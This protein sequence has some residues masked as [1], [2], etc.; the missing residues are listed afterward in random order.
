MT[1]KYKFKPTNTTLPE[2]NIKKEGNFTQLPYNYKPYSYEEEKERFERE[3]EHYSIPEDY[4]D[5]ERD[6]E[7]HSYEEEK[8][9]F[10]R[11]HQHYSIS[12]DYRD[13]ERDPEPYSYE[14]EQHLIDYS[15]VPEYYCGSEWDPESDFYENEEDFIDP[16]V[17]DLESGGVDLST[18]N[19]QLPLSQHS[20]TIVLDPKLPKRYRFCS[21]AGL[22]TYYS[23][24][25]ELSQV[26]LWFL[27]KFQKYCAVRA[28]ISKQKLV[29]KL[30]PRYGG[31]TKPN[32]VLRIYFKLKRTL[33]TR[34]VN[35]FDIPSV[36]SKSSYHPVVMTDFSNERSFDAFRRKG[37]NQND[38]IQRLLSYHVGCLNDETMLFVDSNTRK[39]R[40]MHVNQFTTQ[41]IALRKKRALKVLRKKE[42][43]Y[44]LLK[45]CPPF[46]FKSRSGVL[47]Y[48]NCHMHLYTFVELIKKKLSHCVISN[49][50][51]LFVSSSAK[52]D[53][54]PEL[55]L[56]FFKSDLPLHSPEPYKTLVYFT[57]K[58]A[59]DT[60]NLRYFDLEGSNRSDQSE[61]EKLY[62]HRPNITYKLRNYPKT[63]RCL[64]ND[65][66]H[67]DIVDH[68]LKFYKSDGTTVFA[69]LFLS[70]KLSS[71]YPS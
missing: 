42:L 5:S 7:P 63:I 33:D 23:C 61:E 57:L 2:K 45:N 70:S 27:E 66:V 54:P 50:V 35:F 14:E 60:K 29:C 13:S 19:P 24:Q 20:K 18:R 9:R 8:E 34:N 62:Y 56:K 69:N 71:K 36:V 48:H 47:T 6:P 16:L 28:I 51:V 41:A 37:D 1:K 46:R 11:E 12:E 26:K 22:L 30:D 52:S 68:L 64:S 67:Q 32:Y 44:P 43:K 17:A 38:V 55:G 3:H 4:R 15:L 10:E 25:C 59:L 58:K 31:Y 65:E 53:L 39:G 21:K 40:L 49:L